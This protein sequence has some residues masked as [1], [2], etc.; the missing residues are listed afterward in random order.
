NR[1]FGKILKYEDDGYVTVQ[2]SG[3]TELPG[4]A[5][6]LPVAGDSL[7]VNGSGAVKAKDAAAPP[8][9]PACAV[10]VDATYN[11]VMVYLG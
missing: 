9:G 7:V 6:L 8:N 4:V 2:Y 11:T 3:F 1:L 10:S 5:G